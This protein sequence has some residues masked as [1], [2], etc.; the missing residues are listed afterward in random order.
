MVRLKCKILRSHFKT[1]SETNKKN[2][3][4]DLSCDIQM[5]FVITFISTLVFTYTPL[6]FPCRAMKYTAH[7]TRGPQRITKQYTFMPT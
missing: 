1:V 2:V 5:F 7:A 6:M 4:T 3:K